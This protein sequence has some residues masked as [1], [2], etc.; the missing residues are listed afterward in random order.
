MTKQL[1]EIKVTSIDPN[2]A[3]YLSGFK[4]KYSLDDLSGASNTPFEQD[5]LKWANS[6]AD[7]VKANI[8]RTKAQATKSLYQSVAPLPVQLKS[9]SLLVQI[10]AEEHAEY[11]D[12]GVNGTK[13][14]HGSPYSFK[15]VGVGAAMLAE[16]SVWIAAKPIKVTP[17]KGQSKKSA[18]KE[19]SYVLARS[20]K[21][22]GIK[23]KKIYSGIFKPGGKTINNLK[24]IVG[25]NT[26]AQVAA[27]V[28]DAFMK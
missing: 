5:L 10:K 27:V 3:K 21:I 20:T 22:N 11:Q 14:K 28:V 26:G 2:T 9:G 8:R 7:I 6:T 25:R 1:S 13:K 24:E 15:N 19:L 4:T 17:R 18:N 16:F 23:P 12:K